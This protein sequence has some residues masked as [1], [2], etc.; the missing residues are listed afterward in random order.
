MDQRLQVILVNVAN[1]EVHVGLVVATRP[2]IA[3]PVQTALDAPLEK[4]PVAQLGVLGVLLQEAVEPLKGA[5]VRQADREQHLGLASRVC[6][7]GSKFDIIDRSILKHPAHERHFRPGAGTEIHLQ[8]H[9]LVVDRGVQHLPTHAL[10]QRLRPA[11]PLP[12]AE[13]AHGVHVRAGGVQVQQHSV[14][15][16]VMRETGCQA[17][18]GPLARFHKVTLGVKADA[19][20]AV[21]Q[22]HR[23]ALRREAEADVLLDSDLAGLVH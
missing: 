10:G 18:P 17:V 3:A 19:L 11:Q 8:R 13:H 14:H 2:G 12:V 6:R 23:G 7:R 21:A 20:C 4:R 1:A 9:I 5:L 22:H 15:G 16:A